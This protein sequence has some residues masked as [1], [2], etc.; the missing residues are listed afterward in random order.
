MRLSET[1]RKGNLP[2]IF[3]F[4]NILLFLF[5]AMHPP[6]THFLSLFKCSVRKINQIKVL[7]L[8]D[9]GFTNPIAWGYFHLNMY[10]ISLMAQVMYSTMYIAYH[11][12]LQR[13]ILGREVTEKGFHL[14]QDLEQ[15]C[16]RSEF[17]WG[18]GLAVQWK[19]VAWSMIWRWSHRRECGKW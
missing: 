11:M 2:D 15:I 14:I 12:C 1:V 17:K 13:S 6:Y 8:Q 4:C 19:G 18:E 3:P 9:R 7:L 5:S 10:H 16:H